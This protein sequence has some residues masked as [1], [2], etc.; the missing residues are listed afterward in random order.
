MPTMTEKDQF[1]ATLERESQTTLKLMRA[2]PANRMDFKPAEKSSDAAKLMWTFV[3]ELQV[4]QDALSGAVDFSRTSRPHPTSHAEILKL[5][6][7]EVRNA[8][9]KVRAATEEQATQ[10]VTVPVGP[11]QMGQV[12]TKDFLWM[13]VMDS[14]HHRGQLSVYL[15]MVGAKVPSI[16]GPT[17]DEPWM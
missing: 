3:L 13:M 17:A 4:A 6:E 11:G 15:R 8:L 16:Y 14:V 2:Y 5:Y 9:A 7:A 12:P 10:M 1:L